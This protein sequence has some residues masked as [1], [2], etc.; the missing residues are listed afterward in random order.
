[1]IRQLLSVLFFLH[2]TAASQPLGES[3]SVNESDR[4]DCGYVGVDQSTCEGKGCCWQEAEEGSSTPWCFYKSSSGS[5]HYDLSSVQDTM[6]GVVG[7]LKLVGEPSSTYGDDLVQLSFEVIYEA[8]EY[9]R[10]RI[11]DPSSSRWEIPSSIVSRP[12]VTEKADATLYNFEYT[13]SPF[14][15]EVSRK[16]DG[17]SIFKSGT[18]VFKDQYIELGT[19]FDSSTKTFGLGESARLNHALTPGSTFT[20]WARDEP[21]AVKDVNLYGSFPFYLQMLNGNAHGAML[22]NSN[23]MDVLLTEESL[24]FKAIGGMIDLYVFAGSSPADV[25]KQYMTVVGKPAMM[26]YWSFGFQNCKYGYTSIGEVEAVVENYAAANIPLDVQWMDIDYMQDYKDFTTDSLNFQVQEVAEFADTLHENGQKFVLMVDPGIKVESGYDAYEKGLDADIFI[27]DLYGSENYLAQ[28][29]PGPVYFPDW[30]NP[31]TA[32]YWTQQLQNFHN[33]IDFDGVWIDMNEASNFCN[34]DGTGQVCENSASGGCPAEGASQTDCCLVCSTPEP[35]NSLDFPPYHINNVGGGPVS[36]KAISTSA[37]HYGGVTEYNAH[38][39]FGL[40]EAQLTNEALRNIRGKRSFTLT[41]SSFPSSGAHTAKWSG[42]N[43]AS[44]DDLKSSIITAIDFSMFGVPMIGS[45]ICGFLDD[46][47]EEL[48]ARWI[49]VGAFYP[50]S[51]DHSAIGT[52]DQELYLWDSVAEASRTALGMRYQ[53]LPYLY[54]TFYAAHSVGAM[55]TRALWMNFPSDSKALG[56]DRQFM[57]GDYLLLSPVLDQGETTVN[58]YFPEGAWYSFSDRNLTVVSPAGGTKLSL[59]TPLTATNVHVYGGGIL[60]LQR[61]AMTTVASRKTPFTLLV[62]LSPVGSANGDLFYDD[63]EQISVSEN[64]LICSYSASVSA[65]SGTV[66][67]VVSTSTYAEALT[68]EVEAIQIMSSSVMSPAVSVSLNGK[69]IT[70]DQITILGNTMTINLDGVL[71][72][73]E[74]FTLSW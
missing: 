26:P 74:N 68:L 3:C 51:R 7:T 20:L 72:I 37:V 17:A 69:F 63:G 62:A 19:T 33:L 54:S 8:N 13:E 39:L 57:L 61:S 55:V 42:D 2:T 70:A 50:F 29:W 41:R 56:V 43:M 52:A 22:F 64:S 73:G 9:V 27:K 46:T 6:T 48:C 16:S 44:W 1:M 71:M 49:E 40:T 38:N 18:F 59:F 58:A 23:G 21:A 53:L 14:S 60:P 36:T 66:T 31:D 25:A 10:V 67:G 28:V 47:T 34:D 15:F 65:S 30:L 35:A 5:S 24:T 4:L 32:A 45:D 12:S 11:T